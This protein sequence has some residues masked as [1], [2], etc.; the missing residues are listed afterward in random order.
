MIYVIF[1]IW[2]V[3]GDL[4]TGTCRRE[5]LVRPC[6]YLRWKWPW[7]FST[8]HSLVFRHVWAKSSKKISLLCDISQMNWLDPCVELILIPLSIPNR[9]LLVTW[10]NCSVDFQ[11]NDWP[12]LKS[13]N[14]Q[15]NAPENITILSQI[16]DTVWAL[17]PFIL[18]TESR[19]EFF[20]NTQSWQCCH[21]VQF[22]MWINWR[23]LPVE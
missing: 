17:D 14:R 5:H 8:Q 13:K 23:W 9:R 7:L 6:R 1:S 20:R 3:F 21:F 22:L 12:F 10:A 2:K 15:A 19:I 11:N 4:E 16:H 18:W